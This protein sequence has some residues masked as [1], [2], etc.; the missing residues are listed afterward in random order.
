MLAAQ[1]LGNHTSDSQGLEEWDVH[2]GVH[3]QRIR[4]LGLVH[5]I[6]LL[7]DLRYKIVVEINAIAK[8]LWI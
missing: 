6:W 4:G 1:S 7:N 3:W 8:S 2:D 5:I